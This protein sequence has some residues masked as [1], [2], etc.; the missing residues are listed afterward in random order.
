M[1]T[2]SGLA[3]G[4]IRTLF[5]LFLRTVSLVA[6]LVLYQLLRPRHLGPGM[7]VW[8]RLR[9]GCVRAL[10]RLT[11]G[12]NRFQA[13]V[14]TEEYAGTLAVPPEATAQLLW[15]R[16]FHRNPLSGIRFR[17]GQPE[18]SSWVYRE[19]DASTRQVHVHVF[20]G[21]GP[22]QTDLYTHEEYSNVH[23][24]VAVKHYRGVGKDVEAGIET[25]RERLPLT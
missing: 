17:D 16:G 5:A 14:S 11:P 12:R 7:D 13:E 2:A 18:V 1:R 6:N 20:P 22:E 8:D 21:E 23:P 15:E 25:V 4:T 9:A 10:G 24:G 19:S 3:R